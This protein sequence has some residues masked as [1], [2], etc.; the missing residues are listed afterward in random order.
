[1]ITWKEVHF[2]AKD[3]AQ[4]AGLP[5][6]TDIEVQNFLRSL[7]SGISL[8]I[9]NFASDRGSKLTMLQTGAN[10]FDFTEYPRFEIIRHAEASCGLSQDVCEKILDELDTLVSVEFEQSNSITFE[11][12]GA[13]ER[14]GDQYTL[15]LE[16]ELTLAV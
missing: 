14:H 7:R 9:V 8:A 15:V 16:R 5:D 2:V 1:M 4:K 6:I 11:K 13:F 10:F 12:I 3:S